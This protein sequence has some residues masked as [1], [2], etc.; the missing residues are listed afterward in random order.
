MPLMITT[1]VLGLCQ[2]HSPSDTDI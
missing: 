1:R 2:Y